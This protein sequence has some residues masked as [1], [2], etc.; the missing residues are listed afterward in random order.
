MAATNITFT[1][2]NQSKPNL[3]RETRREKMKK[4]SGYKGREIDFD[5]RGQREK[6]THQRGWS[7]RRVG[8]L[9]FSHDLPFLLHLLLSTDRVC[10]LCYKSGVFFFFFQMVNVMFQ[11]YYW[12]WVR[13]FSNVNQNGK[14]WG[15]MLLLVGVKL[16]YYP[17]SLLNFFF[18]LNM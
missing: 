14:S 7:R 16:G 1:V 15:G 4:P 17:T 9:P 18:F 2:K 11:S 5:F 8:F 3:E 10:W 13:F 12:V 6:R